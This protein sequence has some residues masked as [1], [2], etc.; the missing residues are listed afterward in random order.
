VEETGFGSRAVAEEVRGELP[1]PRTVF[2]GR[3]SRS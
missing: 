1:C 3:G 2:K